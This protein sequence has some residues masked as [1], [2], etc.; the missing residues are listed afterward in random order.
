[1]SPRWNRS[2]RLRIGA[3]TV[4]AAASAGW[5][6]SVLIAESKRPATGGTLPGSGGAV[7]APAIEAA[8]ADLASRTDIR[9]ARLE[10]DVAS[11]LLHL[12]VVEGDFG[13]LT[14]RQ[15]QGIAAAC[16]SEILGDEAGGQSVRWHLQRGERHLLVI[17]LAQRW[18]D[19]LQSAAATA[20]L[21]LASVQPAFIAR[22]NASGGA[23]KGGDGV[24]AVCGS[25]DFAIA[26]VADGAI[27]AISV[28]A[29]V[30]LRIEAASPDDRSPKDPAR[31]GR[32]VSSGFS[33]DRQ[34]MAIV[35]ERVDRFLSG[36]GQDPEEQSAFVLVAADS[37]QMAASTRWSVVR[38][39]ESRA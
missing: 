27:A 16:V 25:G 13:A 18:I 33:P 37:L 19:L 22:W 23:M 14:D 39:P 11:T 6:R 1:V 21:H 5:P 15:L 24:F 36:R 31:P 20:G 35:D 17:A 2:V 8:L 12:D 26:A 3:D 30:D 28:G 10:V 4:E 7:H 34:G 38:P 9:G 29:G 32:M